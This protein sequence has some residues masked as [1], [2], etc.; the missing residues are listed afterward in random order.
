MNNYHIVARNFGSYTLFDSLVI[1][2]CVKNNEAQVIDNASYR[3]DRQNLN[4][5]SI[6]SKATFSM[7]IYPE[8]L[9]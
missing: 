8:I 5:K 1:K 9:P 7:Q 2:G 4:S 6:Q 3:A